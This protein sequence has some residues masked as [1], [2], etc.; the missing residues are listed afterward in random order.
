MYF[1]DGRD[2][3]SSRGWWFGP[4]VGGAEAMSKNPHSAPEPPKRGWV[5]LTDDVVEDDV[6]VVPSQDF[7]EVLKEELCR[8]NARAQA[9]EQR[10]QTAEEAAQKA[11]EE[12]AS[13]GALQMRLQADL[14]VWRLQLH[15]PAELR[16]RPHLVE[17]MQTALRSRVT[18]DHVAE[19]DCMRR[20]VVTSVEEVINMRV[21]KQYLLRRQQTVEVL[22]SRWSCPF[23]QDIA[24][25]VGAVGRAFEFL[26]LEPNT[27]EV[28]LFHGTC[29]ATVSEIV[30][31]GFDERLSH[32]FLYGR[33]IYL[34]PDA[35]K[36][37]QYASYGQ[38]GCIVVARAI[39]GHPYLAAG[40]MKNQDR[41]PRVEGSEAL[42]D[43]TIARPGI[44]N[45]KGKGKGG[46]G[47]L[48]QG[49]QTHWEAVVPDSQLY[50]EY[51]V[52]FECQS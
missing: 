47:K 19:C 5:N 31:Q 6:L 28:L 7:A 35:C 37:A 21:W 1:W 46:W 43:S 30:Q 51:V 2:D 14:E 38:G 39:L 26:R 20:V 33:G 29:D 8:A 45:G 25:A 4:K 23:V 41:P 11:R 17:P 3:S 52:R 15:Q 42:H 34:S 48:Q 16:P 49:L 24:P 9:A 36:A 10:A 18:R 32:R 22:S 13:R 40:P 50:P 27:N 44:P 12:D